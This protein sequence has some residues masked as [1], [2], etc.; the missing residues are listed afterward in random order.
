[1]AWCGCFITILNKISLI[2]Y[3][4]TSVMNCHVTCLIFG[5]QKHQC[6]RT[7]PKPVFI[8]NYGYIYIYIYICIVFNYHPILS[9]RIEGHRRV[10]NYFCL[11][12]KTSEMYNVAKLYAVNNRDMWCIGVTFDVMRKLLHLWFNCTLVYIMMKDLWM[13]IAE[14]TADKYVLW[15][16]DVIMTQRHFDVIMT[17]YLQHVSSGCR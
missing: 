5:T 10:V 1:M 7:Q 2:D 3:W 14:C 15:T 8:V 16:Q 6:K 9:N 13:C 4:H 11:E 12:D 17:L